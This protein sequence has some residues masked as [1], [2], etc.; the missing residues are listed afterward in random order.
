MLFYYFWP[1]KYSKIFISTNGLKVPDFDR[2]HIIFP[3][4]KIFS[5][6]QPLKIFYYKS[7]NEFKFLQNDIGDARVYLENIKERDLENLLR[8]FKSIKT[9][10]F[11]EI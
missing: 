4:F 8:I 7:T 9:I 6:E 1:I 10:S 11:T 3:P 2:F 5:L